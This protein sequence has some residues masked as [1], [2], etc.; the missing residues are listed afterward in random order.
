MAEVFDIY[1]RVIDVAEREGDSYGSPEIQ[2]A[3]CRV[4]GPRHSTTYSPWWTA[5]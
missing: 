2:E 3:V 4:G 1:T 5:S